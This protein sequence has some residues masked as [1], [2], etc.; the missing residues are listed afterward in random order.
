MMI[1]MRERMLNLIYMDCKK[2]SFFVFVSYIIYANIKI[3]CI[4]IAKHSNRIYCYIHI[5]YFL[6]D[7]EERKEEKLRK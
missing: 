5:Y 6:K 2:R 1:N 7:I 3:E 4:Q